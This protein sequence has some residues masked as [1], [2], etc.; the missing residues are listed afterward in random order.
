MAHNCAFWEQQLIESRKTIIEPIIRTILGIKRITTI[1]SKA[2]T[3]NALIVF[4]E[5]HVFMCFMDNVSACM[6][7]EHMQ[8]SYA[9]SKKN[10][11]RKL[12]FEKYGL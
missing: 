1:T 8:I 9:I 7:R 11:E 2:I 4:N 6:R 3:A 5:Q 12:I 10:Y